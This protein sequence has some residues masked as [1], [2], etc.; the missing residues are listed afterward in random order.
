M[1]TETKG[2]LHVGEHL[3]AAVAV[4]IVTGS[5]AAVG[6]GA[7]LRDSGGR[8]LGDIVMTAGA[9]FVA[10]RRQHPFFRAAV[11][12]MTMRAAI[13]DDGVNILDLFKLLL[14]VVTD[15]TKVVARG[16]QL[17]FAVAGVDIVTGLTIVNSRRVLDLLR[18]HRLVTFGAQGRAG[19]GEKALFRGGVHSMTAQAIAFLHRRMNGTLAFALAVMTLVAKSRGDRRQQPFKGGAVR[20]VAGGAITLGDRRMDYRKGLPFAVLAFAVVALFAQGGAGG[21]GQLGGFTGV[22]VVAAEAVP[23]SHRRVDHF[24]ALQQAVVTLGA[25]RRTGSN[26]EF[27][28]IAGVRRVTGGAAVFGDDRVETLHPLGGVIV[29]TCAKV[30][31]FGAEKFAIFTPVRI[32]ATGAAVIKGGMDH[33]L[34]FTH[35]VMALLAQGGAVGSQLESPLFAGV[36]QAAGFM[37]RQTITTSHRV[38]QGHPFRRAHRCMTFRCHATLCRSQGER[39]HR[40]KADPE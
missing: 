35:A 20:G 12:L 16:N 36:R 7:M 32:M 5:A 31:P 33:L 21:N 3:A 17:V 6:D 13:G 30:A 22:G 24:G 26:K 23:F 15:E 40:Q 34:A 38:V 25:K 14:I 29:T 37:A 28:I 19:L 18:R 8:Q 39:C 4:R 9:Q 27:G 2:A 10:A 11:G 1:T